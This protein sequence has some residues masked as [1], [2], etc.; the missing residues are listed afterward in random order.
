MHEVDDALHG[1]RGGLGGWIADE[2]AAFTFVVCEIDLAALGP[3]RC[4]PYR[5]PSAT[6]FDQR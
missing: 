5:R 3:A 2:T 1:E 6:L 4:V